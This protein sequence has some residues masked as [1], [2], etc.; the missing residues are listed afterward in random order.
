MADFPRPWGAD[1]IAGSYFIRDA[2][3]ARP[4]VLIG[5]AELSG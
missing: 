3:V 4:P 2:V 1:K 5:T